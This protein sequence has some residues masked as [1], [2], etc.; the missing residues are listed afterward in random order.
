MSSC[1]T[2]RTDRTERTDRDSN[3]EDTHQDS[4]DKFSDWLPRI[5]VNQEEL[6]Y[7]DRPDKHD[8][9]EP[10]ST[11]GLPRFIGYL[12]NRSKDLK[13]LKE[14]KQSS[15]NGLSEKD[16]ERLEEHSRLSP[17]ELKSRTR[18][19]S[20]RAAEEPPSGTERFLSEKA[21]VFQGEGA[22][23]LDRLEGGLASNVLEKLPGMGLPFSEHVGYSW[24]FIYNTWLHSAGL[25]L[26]PTVSTA[27]VGSRDFRTTSLEPGASPNEGSDASLSPGGV[28][29]LSRNSGTCLSAGRGSYFSAGASW[30]VLNPFPFFRF[31]GAIFSTDFGRFLLLIL[32][33]NPR[34]IL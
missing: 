14:L 34:S 25:F 1:K 17:S 5:S 3:L 11:P 31:P 19:F 15:V 16:L 27:L 9:T 6:R 8:R 23:P 32:G 29:D 2:D 26:N 13:E 20:G 7:L 21:A 28:H 22:N 24:P 10:E 12:A 33:T 18:W 30:K 4:Q